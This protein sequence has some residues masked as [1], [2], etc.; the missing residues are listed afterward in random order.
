MKRV[1][2]VLIALLVLSSLTVLAQPKGPGGSPPGPAM[3]PGEMQERFRT[4]Q[5]WKLTEVL[6]LS[7]AQADKFFPMFRNFQKD[8][9]QIKEENDELFQKLHGYIQADDG[10]KV[11]DL[12]SKIEKNENKILQ[13]R[14]EFRQNAAKVLDDV[15][16]GKLIVFQHEFPRHF[17]E[18]MWEI[19]GK[20]MGRHGG[21]NHGP[22]G[23]GYKSQAPM[24]MKQC[25]PGSGMYCQFNCLKGLN[26]Q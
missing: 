7:E 3:N 5:I 1:L 12:I 22:G 2:S 11:E 10:S 24:G 23:K 8:V 26:P 18:V 16:L 20:G 21:G 25:N 14:S 4:M 13:L 15:Q 9:D 19:H 17:R 6:D